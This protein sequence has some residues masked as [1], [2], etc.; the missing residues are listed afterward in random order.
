MKGVRGPSRHDVHPA[1]GHAQ[2]HFAQVHV[3]ASREATNVRPD[4][5]FEL[6]ERQVAPMQAA[7]RSVRRVAP[8]IVFGAPALSGLVLLL[9]SLTSRVQLL[10]ECFS[11]APN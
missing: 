6:F 11:T 2:I 10:R 9:Q 7:L 1:I 5:G 4:L 3:E 8:R